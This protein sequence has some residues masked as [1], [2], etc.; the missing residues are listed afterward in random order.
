MASLETIGISLPGLP[1]GT[2]LFSGHSK[3]KTSNREWK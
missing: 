3:L 2:S 1:E